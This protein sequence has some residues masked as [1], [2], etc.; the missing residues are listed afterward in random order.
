MSV[1]KGSGLSPLLSSQVTI[2]SGRK[3]PSPLLGVM[4]RGL[5]IK[6]TKKEID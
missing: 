2:L 4:I 3:L 1:L 6:V 5:L